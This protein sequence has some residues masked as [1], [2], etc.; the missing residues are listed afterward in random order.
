MPVNIVSELSTVMTELESLRAEN[1]ILRESKIISDFENDQIRRAYALEREKNARLLSGNSR[2][3]TILD[4]AG[5]GLVN[6]VNQYNAEERT[7]EQP[8]M[9]GEP[10]PAKRL[11]GPEGVAA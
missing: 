1:K 3:K 8:E 5:Q 9:I 4:Q 7:R 2:L 6:G 10:T 11:N